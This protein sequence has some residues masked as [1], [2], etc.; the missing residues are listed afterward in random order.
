M[1]L[2]QLITALIVGFFIS[3]VAMGAESESAKQLEQI[4][5]NAENS[6]KN[7]QAYE[8]NQKTAE[9]NVKAL[10]ENLKA[11]A[12]QKVQIKDNAKKADENV[13]TMQK[14]ENQVQG[15]IKKEN[16]QIETEK[17]QISDL[18]AKI[19]KLKDN[20]LK[21]QTNISEY[22]SKITTL[23]SE[24]N[25]WLEQKSMA[26][27]LEKTIVDK[28]KQANIE[29]TDWKKKAKGYAA[30]TAKWRSEAEANKALYKKYDQLN[31]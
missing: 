25:Q 19:A 17:K 31:K 29:L 26:E 16:D 22:N 24:K 2:V 21:R 23:T 27:G 11:L 10:E 9:Q 1:R 5:I 20:I 4:K 15:L 12:S 6:E 13:A 7:Q 8:K 14:Q 18:E 3:R 28:E 30:E